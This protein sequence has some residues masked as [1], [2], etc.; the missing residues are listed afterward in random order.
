MPNPLDDRSAAQRGQREAGEITA[1]DETGHGRFEI[2]IATRKE[3]EVL[4]KPLASWTPLV[5]M[6]SVPICGRIDPFDRIGPPPSRGR[7]GIYTGRAHPTLSGSA[8]PSRAVQGYR[9][10][11]G[12][13]KACIAILLTAGWRKWR[14]VRRPHRADIT[15]SRSALARQPWSSGDP[16][17][18]GRY[19]RQSSRDFRR[20]RTHWRR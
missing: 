19:A 14:A 4:K 3:I 17:A 6:I 20:R 7:S 5:A 10:G 13:G 16:V 1:E 18:S 12:R 8:Y 2:L 9:Q 11:D 15:L